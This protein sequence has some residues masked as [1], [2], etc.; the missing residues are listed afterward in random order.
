MVEGLAAARRR[1]EASVVVAVG[2]HHGTI[3]RVLDALARQSVVPERFEVVVVCA[4]TRATAAV[5]Q[6]RLPRL[7]VLDSG[8]R[9]GRAGA[10]NLGIRSAT[11]DL[12]VLLVDDIVP[13][14]SFIAAHLEAH[15]RDPR[16]E[17]A[18]IGPARFPPDLR[19]TYFRRWLEDSGDWAGVS[20]TNGTPPPD[21]WWC[22]NTSLKRAFLLGDELLDERLPLEAWDDYELGLRLF[23]RGMEVVYCPEASAIHEHRLELRERRSALRNAGLS[24]ARFDA[25]YPAPHPWNS[26]TGRP[27]PCLRIGLGARWAQLRDAL[28]RRPPDAYYELTLRRAFLRGYRAELRALGREDQ[29]ALRARSRAASACASSGE[30]KSI[31]TR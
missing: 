23:A 25:K 28:R 30:S 10:L 26:G 14:P 8:T 24:A 3:N 6:G 16:E 20:F 29:A 19:D 17:L 31:S 15:A 5:D 12:V 18:A 1:P 2:E 13:D 4:G 9:A 21:F 22:A 11:A 7:R 27:G